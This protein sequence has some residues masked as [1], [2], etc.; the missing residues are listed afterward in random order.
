MM[1]K[2]LMACLIIGCL[3]IGSAI[4]V[5]AEESTDV[6]ETTEQDLS[7]E[8]ETES[9][10]IKQRI[11]E[12]AEQD[13]TVDESA[14]VEENVDNA[15]QEEVYTEITDSVYIEGGNAEDSFSGIQT[16]S[17]K[18]FEGLFY[19]QL[20][21]LAYDMNDEMSRYFYETVN[22]DTL[23][24]E[25]NGEYGLEF[26][27]QD[28]DSAALEQAKE[29]IKAEISYAASSALGAFLYDYPQ[30]FWIRGMEFEWVMAGRAS[31]GTVHYSVTE[32]TLTPDPSMSKYDVATVSNNFYNGMQ[33]AINVISEQIDINDSIYEKAKKIHDW[34][35]AQVTYDYDAASIGGDEYAYAHTAYPVFADDKGKK[36]VCEGY[37][38]AYKILCNHFGIGCTLV[39]GTSYTDS[40][41]G[42]HMWNM[43]QMPD[44]KWYGVDLTWDDSGDK[45]Y[46]TY[47]M[48]GANTQ[49]FNGTFADEH[50]M[51]TRIVAGGMD[52][53]FPALADDAY[54]PS[55]NEGG[56]GVHDQ[57]NY[58]IKYEPGATVNIPTSVFEEVTGDPVAANR[59]TVNIPDL[60]VTLEGIFWMSNFQI[61]IP[62]D[63]DVIAG[64]YDT[65]VV[66]R[67]TSPG[68]EEEWTDTKILKVK[69]EEDMQG[70]HYVNSFVET[71][72]TKDAVFKFKNGTGANR[73]IS[74]DEIKFA[75]VNGPG[76]DDAYS[77]FT[78]TEDFE[79]DLNKGT[80]TIPK[81]WFTYVKE[82]FGMS[83]LPYVYFGEMTFTLESGGQV[84]ADLSDMPQEVPIDEFENPGDEA[85]YF[86]YREPEETEPD[87]LPGDIDANGEVNSGDLAYMLQVTNKRIDISELTENQIRA[88]DVSRQEGEAEG[89]INSGDLAT[90]LQYINGRI[91]SL[92]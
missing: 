45:G 88:G 8:E 92:G 34:I 37:A 50:V 63:V 90:L 6:I 21:E 9:A 91:D 22:A 53:A 33:E 29:N 80:V 13:V 83:F 42:A 18:V 40:G 85:W 52:F 24:F 89:T 10:E 58:T 11:T 57:D 86:I 84:T 16:Y 77:G 2:R 3:V 5:S 23:T 1:K 25:V 79:Y 7:S 76:P 54:V 65:S 75:A 61:K 4:P 60:G 44:E 64:V 71:D 59:I 39:S 78:K 19:L 55:G 20:D 35:N 41:A 14:D 48:V 73:I 56:S 47:F 69:V 81:E 26:T 62:Y 43:V 12:E 15:E 72:G 46:D 17:D 36:V 82:E 74:I 67:Q 87:Y 49:G 38:K 30:A 27:V 51:D 31:G 28:G 68:W 70:V 66:L 32:I